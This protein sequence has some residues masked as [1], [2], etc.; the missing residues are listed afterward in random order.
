MLFFYLFFPFP[1]LEIHVSPSKKQLCPPIF[2][3]INFGSHSFDYYFLCFWC[4][5]NFRF[6][7]SVSSVRILLNS[8]LYSNWSLFLWFF[9][10]V[11]YLFLDFFLISFLIILLHLFFYPMLILMH[12]Y[13]LLLLLFIFFSI[14]S[15]N[16]IFFLVFL[17]N[18]GP[19]SINYYLLL[20]LI[21]FIF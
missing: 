3:P 13:F 18:L 17:S 14:V 7:F 16:I 4:F 21:Y 2:I 5:F 10:L 6:F 20:F 8:F 9:F 11:F 19:Y 12:C 1:D 15:P